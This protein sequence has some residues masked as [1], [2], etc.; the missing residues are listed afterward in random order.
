MKQ[1]PFNYYLYFLVYLII[2]LNLLAQKEQVSKNKTDFSLEQAIEHALLHNRKIQNANLNIQVA[3]Q[4]KWETTTIGLP[5]VGGKIEYINN[6]TRQFGAVDFDQDGEFDFSLKQSV[7]PSVTLQQLIFDGAYLVSLQSSKVFLQIS[8]NAKLK[9]TKEIEKAVVS[10]YNNVLL[11]Q[12]SNLILAKNIKNLHQSIKETQALL[13]AGFI[14]EEALEQLQLTLNSLESNAQNLTKLESISKNLLKLL[15]GYNTEHNITLTDNLNT[16]S[17]E[18]TLVGTEKEN[19]SVFNTIDY[20]IAENNTKAKKLLLKLEKYKKLPSINA[21]AT[22]NYIGL[23]ED[24][25]FFNRSQRWIH[26][27][28]V[29][30][31]IN[32]PIFSSFRSN[33]KIKRAKYNW[34]IAKNELADTQEELAIKIQNTKTELELT[35]KTLDNKKKNLTLAEKI[36]RK[37]SIKYAEGIASSFDLRQ[38]QIQLYQIQQEYLQAMVNVINKKAELNALKN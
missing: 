31:N 7:T 13:K 27:S 36:E 26:T 28:L 8:K 9:T 33:A 1:N 29:G 24:F 35:I 10:A 14:E 15:L 21:F 20:K 23:S 18:I 32:I 3:E 5:Q 30:V 12:E 6:I 16:L 4:Q 22:G 38:A 2:P 25:N 37:N 11:T 17:D 34:Q 19:L